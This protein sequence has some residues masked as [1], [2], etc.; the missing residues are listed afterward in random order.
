MRSGLIVKNKIPEQVKN[1]LHQLL[2]DLFDD[3]KS[4]I[5]QMGNDFLTSEMLPEELSFEKALLDAFY[6][7]EEKNLVPSIGNITLLCNSNLADKD[8]KIQEIAGIYSEQPLIR[9]S[10]IYVKG[11]C[12]QEMLR[13]AAD[14]IKDLSNID[15]A[16]VAEKQNMMLDKLISLP[17][18][19]KQQS[20]TRLE[21]IENLEERQR[22]RVVAHNQG[23]VS[24]AIL[25]LYG[26]RESIPVLE[27][28][29]ITLIT[30]PAKSGKTTMGMIIAETNAIEND[31]DVLWLLTET[32]PRTIEERFE[33]R[34]TLIPGWALRK[35]IVD[36]DKEPYKK[37]HQKY[38]EEQRNYWDHYGHTYLQYIAGA[39]MGAIASQIRMHKRLADSRNR[40]LLVIV[41]YLQRLHKPNKASDVEA[42][43]AISNELK[44]LA[45]RYD[46]HIILFSQESFS[47]DGKANGDSRAHG[48][49][50]PIFVA[51]VHM[52]MKVLNCEIDIQVT[53]ENGQPV[54]NRI[55]H[56]RYWQK[57]GKNKRQSVVKLEIL[58]ANDNETTHAFAAFESDL[59]LMLD[60]SEPGISLPA[61]VQTDIQNFDFDLTCATR[62]LI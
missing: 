22:E 37:V 21:I 29:D 28:G 56:E 10:C 62:R 11:Y 34:D 46:C 60:C 55:G 51:Q 7:A 23:Q 19:D 53:D 2:A 49:N 36:F 24:G 30:A 52:A 31:I 9:A 47:N 6:L 27:D 54:F 16:D 61:F 43:A 45:V 1:I 12:N 40:P 41:D 15:Y 48:S 20:F 38:I 57:A 42:I 44:D 26:L 13:R 59:F 50:T 58:R 32:S 18:Q 5:D 4:R 8:I 3:Q 25:P 14:E 39:R 17:F 35:G 33:A